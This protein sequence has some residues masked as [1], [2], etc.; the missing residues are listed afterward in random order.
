MLQIPLYLFLF[1]YWIFVAVFV[2]FMLINLYHIIASGSFTFPSFFM[3]FFVFAS[4]TL[5]MYFTWTAI[6]SAGI[7]FRQ[8][9]T[10]FNIDWISGVF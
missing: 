10:L 2:T 7:N 3:T 8:P 9:V 6:T 4:V 5:I 1:L